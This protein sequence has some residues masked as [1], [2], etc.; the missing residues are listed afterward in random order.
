MFPDF[1]NFGLSFKESYKQTL[2]N[3]NLKN[4]LGNFV[5]FFNILQQNLVQF[6]GKNYAQ[7]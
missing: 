2:Y 3:I 1:A 7:L 4:I 6:V 5:V